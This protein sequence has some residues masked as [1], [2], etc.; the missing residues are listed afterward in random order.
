MNELDGTKYCRRIALGFDGVILC[1][2]RDR[3]VTWERDREWA[4][5]AGPVV[6]PGWCGGEWER[7]D[8]PWGIR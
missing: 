3:T 6:T 4:E 7:S 1:L 5:I 2:W 8:S